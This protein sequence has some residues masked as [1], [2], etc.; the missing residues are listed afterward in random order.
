MANVKYTGDGVST[1][2]SLLNGG[3]NSTS[4][5]LGLEDNEASDLLN[6]DFDI[7]G[8]VKKRNGYSR[9]NSSA[10]NS[11]Q[12]CTGLFY[13]EFKAADVMVGIFED[14]MYKMD[15]L[16]GT[17]DQVTISGTTITS[18]ANLLV[19]FMLFDNTLVWTNNTDVP[20]K[21]SGSGNA[22]AA[23]VPSGLT[24][25]KFVCDWNNY[26]FYANVT[27]SSVVHGSRLYWS[28][29]KD[30]TTWS[31]TSF[32]DVD[33]DDGT[34]ISGLHPLGDR[35][36]VFK[37]RSIHYLLFTGDADIPFILV[38]TPSDVGCVSGYSIQ[39][40]ENGL[41][42]RSFDGYYFFDGTDSIK[43]SDKTTTTLGTFSTSR[44]QY[45]TSCYQKS[46]NRYWSS[47]TLSGGTT[48]SRNI[49]YDTKNKAFS[50]YSGINANVFAIA[51]VQGEE[52]I[53]FGD[54]SGYVYR[55]DTG[56]NDN[57]AGTETAINS[58]WKSKWFTFGDLFNEKSITNIMLYYEID[59]ATITIGY[60]YDLDESDQYRESLYI[61]TSGDVYGTALYDTAT[62]AVSGGRVSRINLAG[63]GRMLRL[64]FYNSAIDETFQING[65]GFSVAL[66][67]DQ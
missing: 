15:D 23:S 32:I 16:D 34:E 12:A 40:A 53:Y 25:A 49:I 6:V 27:V 29:I 65:I 9:L 33:K 2:L 39:E 48:H 17:W 38:K 4:S 10:A 37:E 30:L 52:R 61:G 21:W 19:D 62:Y 50:L 26:G 31:S 64:S 56:L 46:K 13:A 20:I 59:T 63:R 57:P 24:K 60:S 35:L 11:G 44:L 67:T 43:F 41:I 47:A 1:G 8:S 14:K 7:F 51:Y 45:T 18:G 42:F 54:Y 55:A 28:G 66:E 58:Y 5:A 36:V 3:L 22:L